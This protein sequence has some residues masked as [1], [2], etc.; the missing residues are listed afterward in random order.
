MDVTYQGIVSTTGSTQITCTGVKLVI[1]SIII[2]NGVS[3]YVLT[4]NRYVAGP[5]ISLI[6]IYELTLDA[7]DTIRDTEEYVL[8]PG[9]YIQLISDVA[10]TTTYSITAIA[11]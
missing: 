5:P 10:G 11:T 3:N 7:G 9:D 1:N 8:N 6:P 2:N 4:Y